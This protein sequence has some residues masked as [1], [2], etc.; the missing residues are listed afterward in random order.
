ME[1]GHATRKMERERRETGS[2]KEEEEG[3]EEETA[4]HKY[5]YIERRLL[6]EPFI[7]MISDV[8]SSAGDT[9]SFPKPPSS[10]SSSSLLSYM[11]YCV[12]WRH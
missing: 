7:A 6:Y 1:Q 11:E 12:C 8:Y 10:P 9:G 5:I 4:T 3:A 2:Q